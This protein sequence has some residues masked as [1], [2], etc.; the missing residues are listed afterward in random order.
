MTWVPWIDYEG[1]TDPGSLRIV[2]TPWRWVLLTALLSWLCCRRGFGRT[3]R[4]FLWAARQ[5]EAASVEVFRVPLG[6]EVAAKVK[7]AIEQHE[8]TR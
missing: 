8:V 2:D 3:Y 4:L 1:L 7:Q 6:P 5:T